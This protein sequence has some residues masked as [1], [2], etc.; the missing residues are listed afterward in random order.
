VQERHKQWGRRHLL[1]LVSAA[2]LTT[3]ALTIAIALLVI[4]LSSAGSGTATAAASVEAGTANI[5]AG[6]EPRTDPALPPVSL[7]G[8]EANPVKGK[9]KAKPAR[10]AKR[11]KKRKAKVRVKVSSRHLKVGS[12]VVVKGRVSPAGTRRRVAVKIGNRKI[13][14]RVKRSNG[15]FRVKTSFGTAGARK[16]RVRAY[17]DRVSRQKKARRGKVT[18]YR[19]VHASYYG[20]GLYGNGMACGGRLSPSTVGVAHKTLPCGTKLTL[21]YGKRSVKVRVVD[22]GPYVAGR[23]LDLT[24]A[25]RNAL[26]VGSTGVVLMSR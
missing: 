4:G 23:E 15:K 24:S 16:I 22:R 20:P 14:T 8:G 17:T 2:T 18:F 3:A 10:K 25:T 1:A 11:Q 6:S 13:V 26:G 5:G 12:N 19:P 21:R 9:S 7:P